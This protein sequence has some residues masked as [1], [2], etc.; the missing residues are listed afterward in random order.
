[1]AS[2]LTLEQVRA[3]EAVE[4]EPMPVDWASTSSL[5]I[6]I[7]CDQTHSITVFVSSDGQ[8]VLRKRIVGLAATMAHPVQH[9]VTLAAMNWV[10]VVVVNES[11]AATATLKVVCEVV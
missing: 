10:K 11:G 8:W 3:G 4:T 6:V 9:I 5:S 2:E 7:D 1:V